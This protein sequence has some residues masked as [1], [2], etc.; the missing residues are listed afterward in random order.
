MRLLFTALACLSLFTSFSQTTEEY[1]NQGNEF[2]DAGEYYSAIYEYTKCIEA[3][4]GIYP[5]ALH[6]RATCKAKI[7]DLSSA[8]EDLDLIIEIVPTWHAGYYYRG[9]VK[10]RYADDYYGAIADFNTSIDL[11]SSENDCHF[12]VGLAKQNI[13]DNKGACVD[14]KKACDL[15]NDQG[16][17]WHYKNCN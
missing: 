6:R 15:G 11:G 8:F 14:W 4:E 2:L 12:Y 5:P 10:L 17:E 13:G 9:Y 16:C 1:F 3:T 7:G